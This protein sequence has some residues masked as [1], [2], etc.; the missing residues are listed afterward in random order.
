[1]LSAASTLRRGLDVVY[2]VYC[3]LLFLLLIFGLLSICVLSVPG[4]QRRRRIAGGIIRGT[5]WLCASPMRVRGS[6]PGSKPAM[7][8]ANHASYLDGLLLTAALPPDISYVVKD[9]VSDWLLVGRVLRRLDVVF[10][11]REEVQM[12][13]RQ[14]RALLKRLRNG[15]SLGIFP[16]GTF[17]AAPGLL[18]FKHGAF[19]LAART[20]T[21]V[22]PVVIHGSRRFFGQGA[23]LPARSPITVDIL[24]AQPSDDTDAAQLAYRVRQRM[25]EALPEEHPERGRQEATA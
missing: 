6:M 22:V 13:A 21:T 11:A 8:V 14:T 7:V 3:A 12:S 18:P 23:R 19:L 24:E 2:G 1:M 17:R 5:L 20:G 9:D 16:E 25:Q 4:L 10:I 15:D